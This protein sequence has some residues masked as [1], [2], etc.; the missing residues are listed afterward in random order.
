M[1]Q[2]FKTIELDIV[3]KSPMLLSN[4]MH[5]DGSA[6]YQSLPFITG[7]SLRGAFIQYYKEEKDATEEEM[8][9]AVAELFGE[10]E[11][12][13]HNCYP[14]SSYLL[15]STAS[16]CKDFPGFERSS[17]DSHGVRDM[18]LIQYKNLLNYKREETLC[19]ECGALMKPAALFMS[20]EDKPEE[21]SADYI[22]SG[23]AAI[24]SQTKTIVNGRLFFQSTLPPGE[25]FRGTIRV[26]EKAYN[27]II[28]P[29]L[30]EA[31]Q[32][33]IGS[34][35]TSG[36]GEVEVSLTPVEQKAGLSYY[37]HNMDDFESR[38]E[39]FQ[40][41]CR[42]ELQL[43]GKDEWMCAVTLIGDAVFS[44]GDFS[45]KSDLQLKEIVPEETVS[46]QLVHSSVQSKTLSGWNAKWG[47]A[48]DE[49][50]AVEKG[51]CYLFRG[52]RNEEETVKEAMRQVEEEGIGRRREAGFGQVLVCHP[53]HTQT[54]VM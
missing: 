10:K 44:S 46:G 54:E 35:K 48:L 8:T 15:P 52:S 51:S 31:V 43:I 53:F 20:G 21:F 4:E 50:Y 17:K 19:P 22:Q 25:S 23:H 29:S 27:S 34:K 1:T 36:L 13:F 9:E 41:V 6:V 11:V 18:L 16:T 45:A 7:S 40:S 26:K 30:N 2:S 37:A 12:R 32:L 5:G 49:E 24:D 33:R 47:R 28:A 3:S 38:W 14:K 39:A 42:N